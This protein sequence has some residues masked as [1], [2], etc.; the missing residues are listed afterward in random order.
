MARGRCRGDS[1]GGWSRGDYMSMMDAADTPRM[2]PR[3][4]RQPLRGRPAEVVLRFPKICLD[5]VTF[6][7][8]LFDLDALARRLRA[9]ANRHPTLKPQASRLLEGAPLR[10]EFERSDVDRITGLPGRTAR[11]VF[12]DVPD[13]GLLA[14]DPPKGRISLC[15]PT[16]SL[17]DLFPTLFPQS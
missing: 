12:T 14:S 15:C 13:P 7:S 17:D 10:G 11:R 16:D 9:Y 1:L 3:L 4:V 8:V 5:Q 6:M 2:R